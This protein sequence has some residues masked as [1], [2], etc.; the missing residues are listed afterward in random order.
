[1]A[2]VFVFALALSSAFYMGLSGAQA[3][4]DYST[5]QTQQFMDW[6][7]GAKSNSESLCSC[8]VKS[9]AQTV[10]PV[11][12]S[13]FLASQGKFTLDQTVVTTTAMVT[14]ALTSCSR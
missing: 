13:Q 2:R 14:Q 4:E 7:T 10:P 8:T 5:A 12:L 3:L 11:A 6:C 1:M 9:L